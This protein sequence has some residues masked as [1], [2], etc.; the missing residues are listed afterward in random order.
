MNNN[1][2]YRELIRH[3]ITVDQLHRNRIDKNMQELGILR[4]QHM[5]LMYIARKGADASQAAIAKD[6]GI[7]P[8]AVTLSIK[9]LEKSGYIKR[10]ADETDSRR[11]KLTLTEKGVHLTEETADRFDSVDRAMFA[12]FSDEELGE[13]DGYLKRIISNLDKEAKTVETVV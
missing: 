9:N 5:I 1:K 10:T 6:F 4:N 7:S 8:A 11:N 2:G 12:G 13:L 3:F